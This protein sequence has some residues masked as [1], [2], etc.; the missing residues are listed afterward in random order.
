MTIK[1]HEHSTEET[2]QEVA[3]KVKLDTRLVT[4]GPLN[5]IPK[6]TDRFQRPWV[7]E[8]DEK[9]ERFKLFRVT[10]SDSTSDLSV[11]GRYVVRSG[12]PVIVVEHKIHF[13]AILGFAGIALATFGIFSLIKTK[14]IFVSI[15]LQTVLC[16]FAV[17][18]YAYAIYRD[19]RKNEKAIRFLLEKQ[20][21]QD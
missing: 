2:F 21:K 14:G 17:S 7:G 1:T 15:L 10:G 19:L 8:I 3:F 11:H 9:G 13:T 16:L 6:N 20:L 4:F 12:K 5:A 18:G